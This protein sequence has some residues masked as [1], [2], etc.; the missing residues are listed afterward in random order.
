MTDFMSKNLTAVITIIVL[1]SGVIVSFTKIE[2]Q[3]GALEE[4]VSK[5]ERS[6]GDIQE[7]LVR[8]DK[9]LSLILCKMDTS[10]CFGE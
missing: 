2:S 6:N 7:T 1:V 10:T 5:L 4:R 3:V 9:R 8:I